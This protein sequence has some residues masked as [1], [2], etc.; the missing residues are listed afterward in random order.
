MKKKNNNKNTNNENKKYEFYTEELKKSKNINE[1]TVKIISF[2]VILVIVVA[3][4][5]VLY[6]VNGKYVSKDINET[7]TTEAVTTEP[8]Y[9]NTKVTVNTMFGISKDT[10]Y[11]LA[12]DSKDEIDG[13]YLYSIARSY[14]NT[15]IK[16]YTLDL[17]NAMNKK[18]YDTKGQA[19]TKPTKPSDVKFTTNTLL[20]FK[21]GKVVE[22]I[23]DKDE[24]QNKLK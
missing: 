7:T 6:F 13:S 21:K 15:K 3:I 14:S 22:F 23:T 2:L 18:Y 5:V 17:A 20:V 12:Y 1:D 19:N 9:D 8:I 4:F 24:I 16:M 11:V 10:Y